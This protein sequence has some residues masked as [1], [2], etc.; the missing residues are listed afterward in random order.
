[1]GVYIV[2]Y[3]SK[4]LIDFFSPKTKSHAFLWKP[5]SAPDEKK[6]DTI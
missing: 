3:K 1:M 2:P 5:I 4:D 6:E